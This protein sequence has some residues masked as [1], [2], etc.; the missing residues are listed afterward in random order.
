MSA[1]DIVTTPVGDT[2]V[3]VGDLALIGQAV[4]NLAATS[5]LMRHATPAASVGYAEPSTMAEQIACDFAAWA[6]GGG[7]RLTE[8]LRESGWL[9][10]VWS[11]AS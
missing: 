5:V 1:A 3:R 4:L 11:A 10:H 7:D 9:N 8:F 6:D 2:T